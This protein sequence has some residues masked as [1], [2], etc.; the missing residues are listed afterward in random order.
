MR[1]QPG[2]D[3]EPRSISPVVRG[4]FLHGGFSARC[5]YTKEQDSVQSC[6]DK[7]RFH[8]NSVLV[9]NVKKKATKKNTPPPKAL[10]LFGMST[11]TKTPKAD[12]IQLIPFDGF[13]TAVKKVLSTSK[14]ESDKQLAEF[15]ASNAKKREA[16]KQN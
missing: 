16:K 4:S 13:K 3:L 2:L 11:S 15:Q 10:L 12:E 9:N 8:G 6:F 5:T 1:T 7:E 14:T